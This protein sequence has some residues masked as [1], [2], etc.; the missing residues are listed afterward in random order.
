MKTTIQNTIIGIFSIIGVFT[1]ISGF[2]EN[3]T[4]QQTPNYGIPES[5]IW[6]IRSDGED[7]YMWNKKTG[8]V[9]ILTGQ[10]PTKKG[11]YLILESVEK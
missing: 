9:R 10:P 8:E 7:S 3:N 2:T 4:T 5:H 6:D 1:I 11:G